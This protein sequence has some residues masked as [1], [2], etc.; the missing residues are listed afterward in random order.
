MFSHELSNAITVRMIRGHDKRNAKVIAH[1]FLENISS[2]PIT[3]VKKVWVQIF[4]REYAT[5]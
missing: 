2:N 4:W 3:Q 1:K 5:R